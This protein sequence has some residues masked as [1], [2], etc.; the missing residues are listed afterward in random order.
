[1]AS[2]FGE[3]EERRPR[4][5]DHHATP[6]NKPARARE[7]SSGI[8]IWKTSD[9]VVAKGRAD[10]VLV[11]DSRPGSFHRIAANLSSPKSRRPKKIADSQKNQDDFQ[12]DT[13]VKRALLLSLF[14]QQKWD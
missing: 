8:W 7:Q 4:G 6:E 3:V 12:K 10:S 14:Y 11:S 1:M 5:E 2:D 9:F 13:S